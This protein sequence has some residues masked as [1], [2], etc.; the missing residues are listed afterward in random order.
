MSIKASTIESEI[1]QR[2]K[3]NHFEKKRSLPNSIAGAIIGLLLVGPIMHKNT[4]KLTDGKVSNKMGSWIGVFLGITLGGLLGY[5][6]NG[7][8]EL[9]F[10]LKDFNIKENK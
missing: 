3:S 1:F 9:F 7:Y 5:G 10:D 8:K 4:E 6:L 2:L